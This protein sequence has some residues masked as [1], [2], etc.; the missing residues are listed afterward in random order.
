MGIEFGLS[1]LNEK[2]WE[3]QSKIIKD[4]HIDETATVDNHL[5]N[6]LKAYCNL[7]VALF[8]NQEVD[9]EYIENLK[10]FLNKKL[11]K[12]VTHPYVMVDIL[13]ETLSEYLEQI[14]DLNN[15]CLDV[16]VS[17]EALLK[18]KFEALENGTEAIH[19]NFRN[20]W[21]KLLNLLH[22]Q[23]YTFALLNKLFDVIVDIEYCNFMDSTRKMAAFWINEILISLSSL[24]ETDVSDD[25]IRLEASK[26]NY[27]EEA[28]QFQERVLNSNSGYLKYFLDSLLKLNQNE[29]TFNDD[30]ISL[31]KAKSDFENTHVGVETIY[32]VDDLNLNDP[33]LLEDHLDYSDLNGPHV[34]NSSRVITATNKWRKIEDTSIFRGCPL[35]VLPHQ[36]GQKHPFIAIS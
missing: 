8:E 30:V 27:A 6:T 34:T 4:Y 28:K 2:Y 20:V 11:K 5:A 18:S 12:N 23:G 36:I 16:L 22:Q 9:S 21:Q 25:V 26:K 31:I 10:S 15:L 7:N 1:W 33:N 35:G 24:K 17:K 13:L 14:T 3:P 19:K 29:E 32:T